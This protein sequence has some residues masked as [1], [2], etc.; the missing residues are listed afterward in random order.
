METE[1]VLA[2]LE[3]LSRCLTRIQEKKPAD[4][5][6]LKQDLDIQDIIVLNLERAV[7]LSVDTGIHILSDYSKT[8]PHSMA[9]VFIE[10]ASQ[11]IIPADLAE[12]MA[13]SVGFRNIAV[14]E[15][16]SI[17]WDI[18]W[19]ILQKHLI[20]FKEYSRI[21]LLLTD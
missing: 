5:L 19:S 11:K 7:Q 13:R 12:R 4:I 21:I 8:K 2:K 15:Y 18:V 9:E 10:L 17:D 20:D 14:H 3:S 6:T 16:E 1:I